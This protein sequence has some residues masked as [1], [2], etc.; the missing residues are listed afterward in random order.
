MSDKD[1]L[2]KIEKV[3]GE[4]KVNQR[5]TVSPYNAIK[6]F[7]YANIP[8]KCNDC[9]YRSRD[10]GGNGKCSVWEKDAA[11]AIRKDIAKF[12]NMIDTRKAEDLKALL[13]MLAKLGMENYLMANAQGRLD[14]NVPDRNTRSEVNSLLSIIKLINECNDKIQITESKTYSKSGDI[15]NLFRELKKG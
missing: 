11:C 15:D 10:D 7:K 2:F 6:N 12:L 1:D 3:S 5:K 14:G 8:A 9:V 4:I 13:D